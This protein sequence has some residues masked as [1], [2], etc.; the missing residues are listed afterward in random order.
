MDFLIELRRFISKYD[1]LARGSTVIVAVS[2][3]V[4]SLSLLHALYTLAPEL[5]LRLHV[6]HLNHQLRG[7]EAQADAD[8]VRGVAQ[9]WQLP[10]TSEARDVAGFA[11]QQRLSLEEAA[12]QVRYGFLLEV[13][14]AQ[15]SETIAVAHNADDQAESVLMHFLRGS[16][17]SGLRGMLPKMRIAELQIRNGDSASR[18]PH[19][20][21]REVFLIRPF[22]ETPRSVIEGYC[23]QH[24]LQPRVDATNADTAYFRNRLRHELLPILATYNPQ[25]R[26]ILRRTANVSAA[27]HEVLQA[28]TDYAWGLTVSVETDTAVTFDLLA[29]REQPL[30]VQR[31]LL[32]KAIRHLRPP[33]RDIDFVHIEEAIGILQRAATGDQATLPQNLLLTVSYSTFTISPRDEL[34]LPDWPLLP[35]RS[36]PLPIAVPGVTP[37]PESPWTIAATFEAC[38]HVRVP[39][40]R[41]AACFDADALPGPLALRPRASA[42]RFHPQGLPGPVRLKDWMINVKIPRAIRDRLPLLVA[43]DQIAWVPGFRVGQPF[44]VS[45]KTLRVIKLAFKKKEHLFSNE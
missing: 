18:I 21:L 20:A 33:L 30:G 14:L 19:A 13:A 44:L 24:H 39:L 1:L 29:W 16:G 43:G 36:A 41:F 9:Q 17:L 35:D 5:D 34:I 40:A 6:A 23:A 32:R 3:G 4:D 25:I 42:D 12:R 2:G 28:H 8:F 31:A 37:L 45:E 11:R 38:D 26:A 7:G 22:L 15:H 10:W 27:E